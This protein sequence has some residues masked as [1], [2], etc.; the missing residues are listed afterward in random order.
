MRRRSLIPWLFPAAFA[1]VFAANGALIYLALQTRPA[2]VDAHPFEDGRTYNRE[3][4]AAATQAALGWKI[5]LETPK[6]AGT[7]G[8]VALRVDDRRGAPVGGLGVELWVRRPVGSLPDLRVHLGELGPGRYG[9]PLTLPLPGQWQ[10]DFVARRGREVFVY[11]RRLV[12][13]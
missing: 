6:K 3:L 1:P 8:Q 11:G 13:P 2:L 4:A 9:A 5:V 7:P 12:V 10:F